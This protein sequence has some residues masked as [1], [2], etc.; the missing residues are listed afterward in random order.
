MNEVEVL[1]KL[2]LFRKVPT[3]A[4]EELCAISKTT[5]FAQGSSV[6]EQGQ[7]ATVALLL[8]SGHLT[9]EVESGSVRKRVGDIRP[10]EIVG[11]QAILSTDGI[12][13]AHVVAREDSIGLIITPKLL[14]KARDNEAFIAIEKHLIGTLARRIRRTNQAIQVA[15]KEANPTGAPSASTPTLRER[16]RS[17][18]GSD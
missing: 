8:I 14:K 15:W 17:L 3:P 6:F 13:N 9:A 11:E 2:F 7:P 5:R 16:L 4:L 18:F 12:R 10:G 1:S